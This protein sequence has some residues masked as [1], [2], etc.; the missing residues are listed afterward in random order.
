MRKNHSKIVCIKLVHLLTYIYRMHGHTYIKFT[1]LLEN[2][3]RM[4]G[5]E[6]MEWI[7]LVQN[8]ETWR[9]VVSTVMIHG[10]T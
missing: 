2:S 10:V 6:N 8:T 9:T 3:G 7:H 5:Y 1:Y 4:I